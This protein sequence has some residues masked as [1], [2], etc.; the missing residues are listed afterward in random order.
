MLMRRRFDEDEFHRA[1][2]EELEGRRINAVAIIVVVCS[3]AVVL[4]LALS[5]I[6]LVMR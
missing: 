5:V 2:W 4:A 1:D 6:G 3:S